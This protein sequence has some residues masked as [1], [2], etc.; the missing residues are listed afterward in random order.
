[1]VVN[2]YKCPQCGGFFDTKKTT[3]CPFCKGTKLD[4]NMSFNITE[5]LK[6]DK[7]PASAPEPELL[8]EVPAVVSSAPEPAD[9]KGS[10]RTV[11]LHQKHMGIDP[12][13]GWLVAMSG[14]CRGCSYQ[15][16]SDNNFIGRSPQMDVCIEGDET[17]SSA[18]HA[19][20]TYDS[21]DRV[22]YLTPGEVRNIVRRNGKPVLQ[23]AELK[24]RDRIEI[25]ST[26][27]MFIP[28]CDADFS[29][30]SEGN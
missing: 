17:V 7:V 9:D 6:K 21:R 15:L 11:S 2:M 14:K 5:R 20:I 27:L 10:V 18:N 25:G 28:L 22:F 1:M 26:T 3:L 29:W 30:E 12:V 16:H 23:P 8:S 24:A 13:V 19:F 4:S